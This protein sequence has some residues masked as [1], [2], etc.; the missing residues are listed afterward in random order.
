MILKILCTIAFVGPDGFFHTGYDFDLDTYK[1]SQG[2]GNLSFVVESDDY[3]LRSSLGVCTI[4]SFK[5]DK[6]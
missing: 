6:K 5:K 3:K 4:A 2:M 1:F